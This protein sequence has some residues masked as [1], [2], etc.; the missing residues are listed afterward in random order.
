MKST[1]SSP[2]PPTRLL[3]PAVTVALRR[4]LAAGIGS[5]LLLVGA[6]AVALAWANS[7]WAESYDR[8]WATEV[9]INA[10]ATELSKTPV[11]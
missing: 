7:P 1:T 5:G 2:G 4:F 10:G 3:R 8:L 11:P 6:T 9:G